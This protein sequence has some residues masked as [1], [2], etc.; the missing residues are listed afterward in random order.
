MPSV[1]YKKFWGVVGDGVVH[2]VMEVLRGGAM[3]EE[4][5]ETTIVLIA[6]VPKPN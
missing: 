4:W 6:K 2:E 1:F 5:N 3:L